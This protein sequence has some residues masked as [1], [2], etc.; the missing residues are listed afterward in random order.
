MKFVNCARHT[1]EQNVDLVQDGDELYFECCKDICGGEELLVW[2]GSCY[3]LSMGIPV[4]LN[5]NDV[6]EEVLPDPE[7]TGILCTQTGYECVQW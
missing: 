5:V 7:F 3:T 1:G 6:K 2:Y 4:G